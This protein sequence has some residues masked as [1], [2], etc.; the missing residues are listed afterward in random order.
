MSISLTAVFYSTVSAMCHFSTI[1]VE[2][3]A[4]SLH[5]SYLNQYLRDSL[6]YF[7]QFKLYLY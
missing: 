2:V 1:G 5:K 6:E 7:V 3:N 4:V